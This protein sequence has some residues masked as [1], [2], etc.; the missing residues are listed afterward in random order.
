MDDAVDDILTGNSSV[1]I[2]IDNTDCEHQKAD[3]GRRVVH[4]SVADS[5]KGIGPP[6]SF[7]GSYSLSNRRRNVITLW[8]GEKN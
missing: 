6:I 1:E 8:K 7:F 5:S 3:F 2:E 4:L